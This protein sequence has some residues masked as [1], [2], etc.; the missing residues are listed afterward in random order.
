MECI[1]SYF[2]WGFQNKGCIRKKEMKDWQN[3]NEYM[4]S[5]LE[6]T[7]VITG[8]WGRVTLNVNASCFS[9]YTFIWCDCYTMW[10]WR[11]QQDKWKIG[12]IGYRT[13]ILFLSGQT[14]LTHISQWPP[15]LQ[16]RSF[17]LKFFY[18][19]YLMPTSKS[20]M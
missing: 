8:M 12:R 17:Y 1:R 14:L 16:R 19:L 2:Y 18:P 5:Y 11:I 9:G 10:W 4:W 3:I 7:L 15:L 13:S 20:T 6:N